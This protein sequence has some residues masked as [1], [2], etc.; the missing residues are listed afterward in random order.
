MVL[1]RASAFERVEEAVKVEGCWMGVLS[2]FAI[3]IAVSEVAKQTFC[4]NIC[5]NGTRTKTHVLLL[6]FSSARLSVERAPLNPAATEEQV[7][8]VCSLCIRHLS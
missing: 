1:W 4:V 8:T 2:I 5:T 3:I 7:V 6:S